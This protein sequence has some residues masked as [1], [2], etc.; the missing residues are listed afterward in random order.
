MKFRPDGSQTLIG[1]LRVIGSSS[2]L[3]NGIAMLR[4][5]GLLVANLGESGGVWRIAPDGKQSPWLT[6]VDGCTVDRVNFVV[7]Y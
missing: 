3:P 1:N 6:D 2:L 7:G 4:D 5:G